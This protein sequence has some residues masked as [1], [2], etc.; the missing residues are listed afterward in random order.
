MAR[1]ME[2][3]LSRDEVG[4][5]EYSSN[6]I[7]ILHVTGPHLPSIDLVDLPG[8]RAAPKHAARET[9]ALV[10]S[11]IRNHDA[12]SVYLAVVPAAERPLN[13]RAMEVVMEFGL[14][15]RCVGAFTKTDELSVD[16]GSLVQPA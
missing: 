1:E 13:S 16:S 7:I 11:H 12:Y 4:E 6:R 9:R 3:I 10:D 15:D 14:Q 8:L 5:G 2:A